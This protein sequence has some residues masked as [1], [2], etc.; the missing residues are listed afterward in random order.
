MH[1]RILLN[2][3]FSSSLAFVPLHN[4]HNPCKVMWCNSQAYSEISNKI[5]EKRRELEIL[6][7]KLNELISDKKYFVMTYDECTDHDLDGCWALLYDDNNS[8]KNN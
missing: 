2:I 7:G 1:L 6:E 5:A 4:L 8:L 3:L